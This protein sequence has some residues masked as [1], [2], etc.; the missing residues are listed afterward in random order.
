MKRSVAACI[1]LAGVVLMFAAE[2]A[3]AAP[4]GRI[5]RAAFESFWGR[6]T[7]VLLT[8]VFLPL[9]II[10]TMKERRAVRRARRD[11]AYLARLSPV[12]RWLDLRE[13]A[14]ACFQRVHAA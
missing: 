6:V 2:P 5:A 1:L 9:I 11:L 8:I 7:L 14:M 3:L 13:R 4:G 12:F 10:S